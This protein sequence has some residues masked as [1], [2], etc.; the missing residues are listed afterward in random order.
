MGI[1]AAYTLVDEQ[2]LDRLV[3]SAPEH[4]VDELERL[5][6]CEGSTVYLDK[7]WDG[8]HFLLTGVSASTPIDGSPLSEAVVGVHVFDSDDFIG[9]T[10]QDELAAI[11]AA[12]DAVDV[13]ALL[14]AADFTAFSEAGL[15][16]SIWDGDDDSL[17]RELSAAFTTLCQIHRRAA[18]EGMHLII[19][20]L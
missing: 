5:E 14:A 18:A 10:E 16:P 6:L 15:Y 8:L 20:I 9:C 7:L 11:I 17:R 3:E 1:Q 19:S 12:L 2:T 13:D 4:L